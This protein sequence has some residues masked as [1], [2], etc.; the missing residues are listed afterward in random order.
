[1]HILFISEYFPPKIMGGGEINISLLA[2]AIAK[3]G[4]MISVLTSYHQGLPRFEEKKRVKIY[5]RLKTGENT[6]TIGSNL[7][8]SLAFPRSV[9]KE[10]KKLN[11]ERKLRRETNFDL[12]HF[13]GTSILAAAELKE[14]KIPLFATI[15]SYPALCPKGDRIYQ[16]KEECKFVCSFSKFL[17]CQSKSTEI[18]KMQNKKHL[19][20]NLLFL[21]YVYNFYSR[22]NRSLK[23]CH[24]I[25]ISRYVHDLLQQ[26]GIESVVIPNVIDVDKFSEI[27]NRKEPAKTTPN[28]PFPAEVMMEKE[29]KAKEKPTIADPKPPT[30]IE[31]EKGPPQAQEQAQDKHTI[32][33]ENQKETIKEKN[34]LKK[35]ILYLGSFTKFKGP[36]VLLQA[37]PGLDCHCDFYG[38][39]V[40]KEQLQKMIEDY[41]LD[42]RIHQAVPYDQ[43]PALY[44]QADII[45][46][47]SI[48][49]EP[50]GRIAIEAM[51]VGKP[52]I[53]SA[54]GG[55]KETI[56]ASE[57]INTGVL[58]E[59]R[60]ITELR[61]ALKR[62]LEN[63]IGS[64][65]K[66]AAGNSAWVKENYSE[67]V[68][69]NK[70][71]EVYRNH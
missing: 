18:G 51:A 26:Q 47:P 34:Q 17:N 46:F 48:W 69:V 16:G 35:K 28:L 6:S 41:H 53:G 57:V 8:R 54:I 45:V 42:A 23:H 60:N 3:H 59:P 14:L 62:L 29:R 25:A 64:E 4:V 39:G 36:Q 67:G 44:A 21:G 27:A 37:L 55:I 30:L 40:M 33:I 24:C 1:M 15:E 12:I 50:F 2:E 71:L 9:V 43:V 65:N 11:L 5:R 49:P 20:Y 13:I 63:D 70:L 58:V 32:F 31:E 7:V 19:K 61:D 68:V 52:V 66:T 56:I 10:V 22:L 38:S